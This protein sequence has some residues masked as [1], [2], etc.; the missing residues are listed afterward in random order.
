MTSKKHLFAGLGIALVLIAGYMLFSKWSGIP[1]ADSTI[2]K[3]ESASRQ[4]VNGFGGQSSPLTQRGILARSEVFTHI[5]STREGLPFGSDPFKPESRAEQKWLDRN[6]Y[7]N[8]E[9]WLAY[10]QASDTLLHQAAANGD[11]LASVELS[12]RKLVEGDQSAHGELIK[13]LNDGSQYALEILASYQAGSQSNGDPM[14][15]YVLYRFGEMRGNSE[16]AFARET[17][18]ERLDPASRLRAEAEARKLFNTFTKLQRARLGAG[19][20]VVDARPI[21][22]DA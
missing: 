10:K 5:P 15:A 14:A 11:A 8:N 4:K 7:P 18:T 3:D 1:N 6:G 19:A 22:P 12:A 20:S 21:G 13:A 16:L 9:Q 17:L 2:A